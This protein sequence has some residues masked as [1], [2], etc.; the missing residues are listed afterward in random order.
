MHVTEAGEVQ[1][2]GRAPVRESAKQN[3]QLH[4][5]SGLI[6]R[7]I[8]FA[9]FQAATVRAMGVFEKALYKCRHVP[10]VLAVGALCKGRSY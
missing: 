10:F 2:A 8:P 6:S 5:Q 1:A 3:H 4:A 9:E 7:R